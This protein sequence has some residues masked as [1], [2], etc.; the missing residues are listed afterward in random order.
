MGRGVKRRL[1]VLASLLLGL[2]L[3]GFFLYTA[4]LARVWAEVR[5]LGPWGG[6]LLF[7]DVAAMV[8]GWGWGWKVVLNAYDLHPSWR[9]IGRAILAGYALSYL[10]PSMYFG[11]EPLRIYLVSRAL[12]ASS[13]QVTATVVVAKMIEGTTL[14]L[15]VLVGSVNLLAGGLLA[16]SQELALLLTNLALLAGIGVVTWG[17]VRRR[18]WASRTC[19]WLGR[20]LPWGRARLARLHGWL[21]EAEWTVHQAFVEHTTAMV[22]ALGIALL[23]NLTLYVR[24]WI[25]FHFADG[26]SFSFKDLSLIFALFFFLSTFLWLTPGGVG[27]AEGG[28][29]GIFQLLN[30]PAA[31]ALAYALTLKAMELVFIAAG[32]GLLIQLGLMRLPRPSR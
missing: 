24:P 5:R 22:K 21:Q 10:T 18:F 31:G 4:G 7:L 2:G 1:T 13:S 14:L 11:G 25:F 28:L 23:T 19:A 30:V 3:L 12:S 32:V 17:F 8:F 20:H 29:V 27:I 9:L 6:G 16:R 26:P 15:L